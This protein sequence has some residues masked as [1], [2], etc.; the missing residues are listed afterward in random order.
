MIRKEDLK[1]YRKAT[2]FEHIGVVQFY[3]RSGKSAAY[4]IVGVLI[5]VLCVALLRSVYC[6]II[7]SIGIPFLEAIKN[8]INSL[9]GTALLLAAIIVARKFMLWHNDI[10]AKI[11]GGHYDVLDCRA[12]DAHR[13]PGDDTDSYFIRICNEL[14]QQCNDPF[15]VNENVFYQ[16]QKDKNTRLMLIHCEDY[17]AV[18]SRERI[19]ELGKKYSSRKPRKD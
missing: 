9:L 8:S 18:T 4:H 3:L 14:G 16:C 12:W 1:G 5:V 10:L 11:K 19:E 6:T 7:S 2:I 13:I 15:K 17:Y